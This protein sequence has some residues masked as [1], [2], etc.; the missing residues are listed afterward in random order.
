M[1]LAVPAQAEVAGQGG[2]R[3]LGTL[4]NGER[5]GRCTAGVCV[6]G[7]G[8]RA[9]DNLFHRLKAFDT[10]GAITGVRF[11]NQR[12]QTVI[13]GVVNPFGSWI[14]KTIKFENPGNLLFLSP[15]GIR[16]GAGAGFQQINQLGLSTATRL[17]MQGGGS[18]DV[19]RTTAFDAATL[20]GTPLFNAQG[21]HVDADA[22]QEAGITGVPG[23]VADGIEVTVDQELFL[24]AMDGAVQV[25][26]SQITVQPTQGLG[27]ALT[28]TGQSVELTGATQLKAQGPAGGGEIRIGGGQRGENLDVRNAQQVLLDAGTQ[29]LADATGHGAGGR[30]IVWSD[31]R[32]EV[33]GTIS[34]QGGPEGGDGGFVETSSAQVLQVTGRVSTAA[35]KGNAGQWLLDPEEVAITSEADVT[36]TETSS[37][38]A[39]SLQQAVD[40]GTAV[41]VESQGAITGA[42]QVQPSPESGGTLSTVENL[43]ASTT[44]TT[45]PAAAVAPSE[46]SV[47]TTASDQ[48]QQDE[49]EEDQLTQSAEVASASSESTT[50][51]APVPSVSQPAE[52]PTTTRLFL[53]GVDLTLNR[54]SSSTYA[55]HNLVIEACSASCAYATNGSILLDGLTGLSSL[56]ILAPTRIELRGDLSVA[57]RLTFQ[58][59]VF[60][61]GPSITL[62]ASA[63]EIAR[64]IQLASTLSAA[65]SLQITTSQSAQMIQVGAALDPQPTAIAPLELQGSTLAHL[66]Q[67][68]VAQLTIGGLDN[69][70]GIRVS[71]ALSSPQQLQLTSRGAVQV[72]SS[73]A[74]QA[75]QR[76]GIEGSQVTIAGSLTAGDGLRG[77][78]ITVVGDHVALAETARITASGENSG[79]LIQLGGSWQNSNSAIRQAIK[80]TVASGARVDA[81]ATQRGDGGT[82]VVWSD[83]KD[84]AST[85]RAYGAFSANG[86]IDGGDGGRIETSGHYLDVAGIQISTSSVNGKTGLWLLDPTD[87]LISSSVTTSLS[88]NTAFNSADPDVYTDIMGDTV[89][90]LSAADL[91][92]A[93]LNSSV[94]VTTA[95]ATACP[96]NTTCGTI[97]Y[98]T[99][100]LIDL[101][102]QTSNTLTLK[103]D[104]NI[105]FDGSY[106]NPGTGSLIL[107]APNGRVSGSGSIT[108]GS[109]GV[110][111]GQLVFEVG[112]TGGLTVATSTGR[113]LNQTDASSS[114]FSGSFQ[115]TGSLIKNGTGTL[116]LTRAYTSASPGYS[117]GTDIRSGSVALDADLYDSSPNSPLDRFGALSNS[118]GS[119]TIKVQPV[120]SSEAVL[121]LSG[122][123]LGNN[124]ALF[125]GVLANGRQNNYT[126]YDGGYTAQITGSLQLN[127]FS[128]TQPRIDVAYET[129]LVGVNAQITHSQ[130]SPG[131]LNKTGGGTLI[132]SG[133]TTQANAND[134]T[135]GTL[136]ADGVVRLE[137]PYNLG[138][139]LVEVLSGGTLDLNGEQVATQ[140]SLSLSGFGEGGI[141]AL[142]N[143]FYSGYFYSAIPASF[144]GQVTLVGSASI[145]EAIDL[146]GSVA[147]PSGSTL[148]LGGNDGGTIFGVISGSGGLVKVGSGVW[149]LT[150]SNTYSGS[151]QVNNGYLL[152]SGSGPT[153]AVCN[154][155]SSNLCSG[156]SSNSSSGGGGDFGGAFPEPPFDPTGDRS[157]SPFPQDAPIDHQGFPEDIPFI[158]EFGDFQ[159]FS[160]FFDDPSFDFQDEGFLATLDGLGTVFGSFEEFEDYFGSA[161]DFEAYTELTDGFRGSEE[162]LAELV[163]I[164]GEFDELD[165]F[166]D[167]TRDINRFA[168]LADDFGGIDKFE[169]FFG[170]PA[171]FSNFDQLQSEIERYSPYSELVGEFN[172]FREFTGFVDDVELFLNVDSAGQGVIDNVDLAIG[173]DGSGPD[174]SGFGLP[175]TVND[176]G[177]Q[178]S[179]PS[180]ESVAT[181]EDADSFANAYGEDRIQSNNVSVDVSIGS[182]FFAESSGLSDA[183]ASAA[184]AGPTSSPSSAPGSEGQPQAPSES[185]PATGEAGP[186]ASSAASSVRSA[187][188]VPVERAVQESSKADSSQAQKALESLL[189]EASSTGVNPLTPQQIRQSLQNAIQQIRQGTFG[190][191]RSQAIPS[192][193]APWLID[194]QFLIAALPTPGI[195]S[196]VGSPALL[197]PRFNRSQ[198]NPA[199]LHIRFTE[200]STATS[201]DGA[202]LDL[203]LMPSQGQPEGRRV[204]VLRSEFANDLKQIYRQLS[205]QESLDV[206]NPQSPSRRL[207]SAIFSAIEPILAQQGI[208]TLLISADRGLQAVPFAALH[209]GKHYFG[210]AFA[211]SLTPSLALTSL[212]PPLKAQGKLLAAG[213]AVFDGLAPLPLVPTELNQ[214]G[215]SD[216]KDKVLNRDFTPSTLMVQAG[217]HQYSRVHIATHAE[218]LPG[219]P[220]A[221]RLYSGTVPIPLTDFVKLRRDR[222]GAPLD[223]IS[224]SA[225]RTALGDADTELGFVGLALQSGA[226]SAVG[227]LWYVDDVATS[228][229]FVQ[230]YRYLDSGVPKAEALQLTRQA[231]IRGLVNVQGDAV[232]GPGGDA[233]IRGLTPSQQRRFER[234]FANPYFWAGIELMG[235]A[236]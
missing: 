75:S 159:D 84:P 98:A 67:A 206:Q 103:A 150:A 20:V 184:E 17:A 161:Q 21:L 126:D 73:A 74:L 40:E 16:L 175:A 146:T 211:F 23:I 130:N 173:P 79:G 92:A 91:K 46:S 187:T 51:Q 64:P 22:R 70:G 109:S 12:N 19:F 176:P 152:V 38:S 180:P 154:G 219:G 182:S 145:N 138:L 218:F 225:C 36:T 198:Y 115:G 231:F 232:V 149:E 214:V 117:G 183:P 18:F 61:A 216:K 147:I 29:V 196:D 116:V 114:Y 26:D 112:T 121:N 31:Q 134:F 63:L 143:S 140:N 142:T 131:R 229:Y 94:E 168:L 102:T 217:D 215:Q 69:T 165:S 77:G 83:I 210:E 148:T 106:L 212:D 78:E 197:P 136:I 193:S 55:G 207:Y 59:D 44:A 233:L 15:G 57:Q 170:D 141:G 108:L 118:L 133:S 45:E 100:A 88:L 122:R 35:P 220:S 2:S 37:I 53:D 107:S 223:L 155:G 228:A 201:K 194:Q 190:D 60:L 110:V 101:G 1:A 167:S 47:A 132:L 39:E 33:H 89:S 50:E 42:D 9:G 8:T 105:V 27:G 135:A 200:S 48:Q 171:D 13:V 137:S 230:M 90:T 11:Q 139:G 58:G 174:A 191:L 151:T 164:F 104:K 124:I 162:Q 30:V 34:A 204:D 205:R 54:E 186:S 226:R 179:M 222:E 80:T 153:S 81:S 144:G 192:S 188:S 169:Q 158:D 24:D 96:T 224:F 97:T 28:L 128:T 156:S 86:G 178:A 87:I 163:G 202:F 113:I 66:N 85:T 72:D 76:L 5:A 119:G 56:E 160:G 6:V 82:I 203:T 181:L 120:G 95:S 172:D 62:A 111:G 99:G 213:S 234:G 208:T 10:R 68:P 209:S 189:P 71:E 199:V 14:D 65:P 227:T 93:L 157:D 25:R 52:T 32:T 43:S 3:S 221:S 177:P 4:I 166:F 236:W 125:G 235:S 123:S 49:E 129:A 41:T 185:G 7:G 127:A 195:Q